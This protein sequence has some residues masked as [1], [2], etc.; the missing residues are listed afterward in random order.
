MKNANKKTCLHSVAEVERLFF[1][2]RAQ[3]QF[4]IVVPKPEQGTGLVCDFGSRTKKSQPRQH[5][6]KAASR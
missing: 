2:D 1:S 6:T 5:Q 3:G 4:G